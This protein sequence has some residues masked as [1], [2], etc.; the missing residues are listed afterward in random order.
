MAVLINSQDSRTLRSL[1]PLATFPSAA[2]AELCT[3][4]TV[5]QI[6]DKE[7]F[8]KGDTS[9]D[10][11]YLLD[12]NVTLQADGLVVEV[13]NAESESA[14]FALAHQIP[15]KIDALANGMVRIVRLDAQVVNNPPPAVYQEDK[16]YIIIEESC[17]D[18]DD[19]MTSLLRLPL[20]QSLPPS[21]LQKILI[22]LKTTLYTAGDV[23]IANGD[24][25]N[26][27]Y[28]INK[29]QCLLSRHS[30]AVSTEIRLGAGD[31]FGE[32]YLFGDKSAQDTITA[33]SDVSIIQLDKRHFLSQIK[34]PLLRFISHETLPDVL[35]N[36]AVLLDVRP[37][38]A[39][40]K[41]HHTDSANIP[42][43]ALRM[44]MGEIPKEKQ[45]IVICANGKSSEAAAFLLLK[46]KFDATVLKGGM[47]IE[48]SDNE[49]N[50]P[51]VDPSDMSP[52]IPLDEGVT[53][54]DY[55][56]DTAA[57]G[58]EET[59]I[60]TLRVENERLT[61]CNRNLEE[62]NARLKAEKEQAEN[63][64]RVLSQQI[65]RLKE[66]LNRLTRRQ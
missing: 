13:I 6:Q 54:T 40:E 59:Q 52:S 58:A 47:G 35:S 1:I 28:I 43:L 8:K 7:I 4:I 30:M 27:F 64:C 10:L 19:W 34:E 22:N 32:E 57:Y 36:G 49:I 51:G 44:R 46:N 39:F 20:F 2:F 24:L 56:L 29:G 55:T 45:I 50:D 31:S 3:N 12:G 65:E 26:H 63:Q 61:H 60:E 33:L 9:T 48:E 17:E 18:S 16:S 62:I 14:K 37:K 25:V 15:R 42:L 41:N 11:V 38:R 66:I 53:N 5:E 21:K 23:I